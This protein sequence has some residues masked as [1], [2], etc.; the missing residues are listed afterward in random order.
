M[1]VSQKDTAGIAG[2]RWS[3]G[4]ARGVPIGG[5]GAPLSDSPRI[6][7][8]KPPSA[9]IAHRQHHP[10]RVLR[11]YP[12]DHLPRGQHRAG[13]TDE[14]PA[15]E[16]TGRSRRTVSPTSKLNCRFC[17]MPSVR[18]TN[19]TLPGCSSRI[20][21]LVAVR[22]ETHRDGGCAARTEYSDAWRAE[23]FSQP[24]VLTKLQFKVV[25][26]AFVRVKI[27]EVTLYGPPPGPLEAKP[28]G[29]VIT[30][31]SAGGASSAWM[32]LM[33]FGVPQPVQRSYPTAAAH[34]CLDCWW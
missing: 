34:C 7:A 29:E 23:T 11:Q 6:R 24:E 26:P 27:W 30:R 13:V 3:R 4:F 22:I 1:L 17:L 20:R 5:S 10:R 33:P 16:I 28:S 25:E 31:F 21:K 32:R 15:R 9:R 18:L 14:V 2:Q 8:I 12:A 19:E